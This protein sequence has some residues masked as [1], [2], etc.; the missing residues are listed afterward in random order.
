M[1]KIKRIALITGGAKRIGASIARHL[2]HCGVDI[3][4]H[5][6]K[7]TMDAKNLVAELNNLRTGSAA[8]I[9]ADLLDQK[10]FNYIIKEVINIF[11]QLDFLINNAST[12]FAT[13]IDS[14]NESNW[15]D[16]IGTNLKAP[17]LLS[18]HAVKHLKKT[19]GSIIN[20]T[21][22]QIHNPKKNYIIY[23]IAKSG[24]AT[25]TKSLAKELAPEI[26]VNA[27]APGAILWPESNLEFDENYRN[28]VISQTLLKRTGGPD[29]ISKAIEFLLLHAPYVTGQT[30]SIDGGRKLS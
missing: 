1:N 8:A 30:L 11:G 2:H 19:K 23:S 13:P 15:D 22:A 16:L 18:H 6:N 9:Q 12:Y 26:R 25:L 7:S 27:I 20:I 21:D 17:L 3:M 24:L 29:D 5:Y 10:S 14:V 4:I 28:K